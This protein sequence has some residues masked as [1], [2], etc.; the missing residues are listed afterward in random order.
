MTEELTRVTRYRAADPIVDDIESTNDGFKPYTSVKCNKEAKEVS[1][2]SM[3]FKHHVFYYYFRLRMLLSR[4]L[5][6]LNLI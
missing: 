1:S 4:I 6:S 3:R 2:T 5:I